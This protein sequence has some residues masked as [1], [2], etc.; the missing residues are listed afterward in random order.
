MRAYE[1]I[2]VYQINKKYLQKKI[3]VHESTEIKTVEKLPP[4]SE[5]TWAARGKRLGKGG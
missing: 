5:R 2:S 4:D 3:S 1:K